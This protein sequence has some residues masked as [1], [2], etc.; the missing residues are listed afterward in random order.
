M[1]DVDP[2]SVEMRI[3]GLGKVPANYDAADQD[4]QLTRFRI[5]RS[6]DKG[7]YTVI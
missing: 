1:G 2:K 5:N 7:N 4:R 3:S 6:Q